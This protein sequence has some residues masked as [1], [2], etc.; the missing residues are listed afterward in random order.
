LF[1]RGGRGS[2]EVGCR[3]F[4]GAFCLSNEQKGLSRRE[5]VL[6]ALRI[7]GLGRAGVGL[8][9]FGVWAIRLDKG[10]IAQLRSWEYIRGIGI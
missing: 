1:G 10:L 8:G 3:L 7:D 2:E 6:E 5:E 9:W 4:G